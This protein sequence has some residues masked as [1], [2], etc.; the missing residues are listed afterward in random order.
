MLVVLD[1][2]DL[3]EQT[4]REF[5]SA[6]IPRLN[7]AETREELQ[8]ML[9][10]GQRGVILTTVF[11]FKGAG[12]LTERDDLVVLVDEAHRS[13]EG[14]LG[15]DMREALPKAT[16]I[17]M[18][19][20]AISEKDRDTYETFGDPG[21]EGH[22][23]SSYPRERSIADGATLPL[24]VEAPRPDLRIDT[25]ALDQAFDQLAKEEGLTD[26]EKETLSKRAGRAETLFKADSRVKA[27]CEDIV[28]HFYERIDPLGMKAQVVCFDRELCVLYEKEISRLLEERETGDE[29]A[30]VMT[31]A[32]KDDPV[33]WKKYDRDRKEEEKLK[34]RFRD[35]GDPLKFLIVTAK[36]LTGFDAPIEGVMYLDKPL[37]KHTL[38]QAL[39]RTNR[40]WINEQTGQEKTHGLIVDYVGLGKQI[41]D[42]MQVKRTPGGKDPLSTETLKE[43]L[44]A[45][46]AETLVRFEGIDRSDAGFEAL[47]AAQDKLTSE[48]DR[49]AFA[50]DFLKVQALFEL[51]WPDP[52]LRDIR[53]DYRWLAKVYASIQPSQ[54]MDALLWDR[55]GA[56]TMAL[57]NQHVIGVRLRGETVEH[58]TIDEESLLALKQLKI[59]GAE[60]IDGGSGELPDPEEILDGIDKRIKARLADD[61]RPEYRSLAERLDKLRQSQFETASDSIEFLKRLLE[62][63]KDLVAAD[64]EAKEESGAGAEPGEASDEAGLLPEQRIGALTQI[65]EEYGPETTPEIVNGVVQEIDAVVSGTRFSHWQTSREGERAV[66]TAI[67]QALK[68]FGLP[69]SGQIFEK[70]YDYVAEHY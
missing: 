18:T 58:V 52:D 27:I 56:K 25:E 37:R 12:P 22:V 41:A 16:F 64:R 38:S 42:S 49:I 45:A 35:P 67:R 46:L 32:S 19:G 24:R 28:D 51:L 63:A 65:F 31:V 60:N 26:E 2:I 4:T 48:A 13:Q 29:C 39:D 44:K 3:I 70:A 10:D 21:D 7:V 15:M 50:E 47:S 14:S 5:K 54:T 59:P 55:L 6:G 36:L 34:A 33:E 57:I 11:R 8:Q 40:R 30:V 69:P 53:S 9:A 43:E 17:G 20:T 66:K 68:K 1:R 62:V 23:M 61:D